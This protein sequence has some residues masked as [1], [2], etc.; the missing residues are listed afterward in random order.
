MALIDGM[1]EADKLNKEDETRWRTQ[2]REDVAAQN[3]ERNQA[4]LE[5]TQGYALDEHEQKAQS[6]ES[7][8]LT[9]QAVDMIRESA[10]VQ[11]KHI[12]DVLMEAQPFQVE[13]NP[14]MQA[15]LNENINSGLVSRVAYN[16][17]L[18]GDIAKAEALERKYGMSST[19]DVGQMRAYSDK[20]FGEQKIMSMYPGA[21][22]N[23]DGSYNISGVR[24]D[25]HQAVTNA[26]RPLGFPQALE[27]L[28]KQQK[29]EASGQKTQEQ[30]A[31]QA[32]TRL[33]N[34]NQTMGYNAY[35]TG[36]M[37]G[38]LTPE[39][40]VWYDRAAAEAKGMVPSGGANLVG[41]AGSIG[42]Y[43]DAPGVGMART[44]PA[45]VPPAAMPQAPIPNVPTAPMA[46]P[47]AIGA[48]SAAPDAWRQKIEMAQTLQSQ[49]DTLD[50]QRK[51][52]QRDIGKMMSLEGRRYFDAEDVARAKAKL[53]ELSEMSKERTKALDMIHSDIRRSPV[54]KPAY[55]DTLKSQYK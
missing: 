16:L 4:Y 20:E 31:A 10:R 46:P 13:G 23:D 19:T 55:V 48:S 41:G 28:Q 35:T 24:M 26:L 53:A 22:K 7:G 21:T 32:A 45:G 34:A 9:S 38:S 39:Q 18:S 1:R 11:G 37:R 30:V 5:K 49:V 54:N 3:L 12:A 6:M 51:N 40:Q 15:R 2:Q 44:A 29:L 14:Y 27:N 52:I 50:D 17:R 43:T 36:A 33:D 25:Y 8:R 47:A 42:T